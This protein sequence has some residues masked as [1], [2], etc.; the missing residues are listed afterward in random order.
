MAGDYQT[1][2]L[3][4]EL[5][6]SEIYGDV[7][8]HYLKHVNG[9]QAICFC[10]S[11]KHSLDLRN[12]FLAAGVKAAHLDGKISKEER[13]EIVS[14]FAKGEIQVMTN[15]NLISEGFDVPNCNAI[16]LARPT[17]SLAMYLQQVGRG[18]RKAED[19]SKCLIFDHVGNVERHGFPDAIR[20]W[21]LQGKT[22]KEKKAEKQK[23]KDTI[24]C[25]NCNF[26]WKKSLQITRCPKC[27]NPT[28]DGRS[29]VLITTDLIKLE[30]KAIQEAEKE[31]VEKDP[32]ELE[33]VKKERQVKIKEL[34]KKC[35]TLEDYLTLAQELGYKPGWGRKQW[36][37][38]E[39]YKKKWAR[40]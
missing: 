4:E 22:K 33:R 37:L 1:K 13:K 16:F 27:Q 11:I 24:T 23:V 9:Q 18:L 32:K 36:E 39:A 14:K 40:N 7:V 34:K 30:R 5:E 15:C 8:E 6:G 31:K 21:T 25:D 35:Q 10:V 17:Q 20:E 3:E 28:S 29:I 12:L 2:A 26:T 19:G 38:K